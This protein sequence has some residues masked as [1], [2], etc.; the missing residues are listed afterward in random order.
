MKKYFAVIFGILS[1]LTSA[2]HG[3]CTHFYKVG[4]DNFPPL[5]FRDSEGHPQG[6]DY[7]V[8]AA[9]MQKMNCKFSVQEM[10]RPVAR[11]EMRRA[12]VDIVIML[13]P[14]TFPENEDNFVTLFGGPREMILSKEKVIQGRNFKDYL[15]DKRV[16]FVNLIGSQS[17]LQ[18][19][20]VEKLLHERRVKEVPDGIKA[21]DL[22]LNGKADA[23]VAPHFLN[24]YYYD[25]F[26]MSKDFVLVTEAGPHTQFGMYISAKRLSFDE[27]EQVR[28]AV[29]ELRESGLFLKKIAAYMEEEPNEK[30]LSK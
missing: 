17:S 6:A 30:V 5:F 13:T 1:L 4:V 22:L 18:Q 10:N 24:K 28:K 11:E 23:V 25:K 21:F 15:N 7:D 29:T 14:G 19:A 20:E 26:K 3:A 27:R 2:S 16:I 12:R 8:I 9:L